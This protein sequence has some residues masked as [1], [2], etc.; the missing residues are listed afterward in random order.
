MRWNDDLVGSSE[1]VGVTFRTLLILS[2][3]FLLWIAC[4]SAMAQSLKIDKAYINKLV[5]NQ[6]TLAKRRILAWYKLIQK[7]QSAPEADKLERVNRFFNLF[8]FRSD[9]SAIGKADYWMTPVEFM[10]AG[11]GDCED[12]AIAKYFTLEALGVSS[13]KMRITYVK[14]LAYNQA[15]MVLTYFKV[16]NADP[17]VLDN[18]KKR[19]HPG[20]K[21]KDLLPVYSFNGNGLWLAKQRGLG[22][23]VGSAGRVSLWQD[24]LKRMTQETQRIRKKS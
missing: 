8:Q 4:Q 9:Q 15:H 10:I 17:L 19:I 13:D 18:I 20:S 12:F 22:R 2:L 14:A 1:K 23:R 7:N 16:P 6:P 3:I 24:L 21:R 11:G 5:R